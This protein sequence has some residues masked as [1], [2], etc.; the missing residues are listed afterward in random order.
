MRRFQVV[1]SKGVTFHGG[2]MQ[3]S[4]AQATS[5]AYALKS[6]G[7]DLYLIDNKPVQFK[8]GE[9]FGFDGEITKAMLIDLEPVIDPAQAAEQA[10]EQ[11]A[12][13]SAS[14]KKGPRRK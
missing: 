2:V 1:N 12:E 11:A 9:E 6:L 10:V 8:C 14:D 4:K 3:L 7:D 13:Q 5:R